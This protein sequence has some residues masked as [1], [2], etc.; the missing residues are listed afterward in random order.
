MLT[1]DIESSVVVR[2]LHEISACLFI[3]SSDAMLLTCVH[4][5]QDTTIPK[6]NVRPLQ[7]VDVNLPK[8]PRKQCP[9]CPATFHTQEDLQLHFHDTKGEEH[10]MTCSFRIDVPGAKKKATL[11]FL[12]RRDGNFL[13]SCCCPDA[14]G[15]KSKQ[16]IIEHVQ[17]LSD[18]CIKEH[19]KAHEKW[20]T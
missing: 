1:L 17:D 9:V 8:P 6:C 14:R 19:C 12:R 3:L 18:H 20:W 7:P 5:W 4:C 11:K 10:N 16:Q 15:F 13:F 2:G